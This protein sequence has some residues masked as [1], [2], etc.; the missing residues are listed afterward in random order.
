MRLKTDQRQSQI[1]DT[2]INIIHQH[3]YSHLSIRELANQVG[4]SQPALYRHFT[5]KDAI[6]LGILDRMMQLGSS[7]KQKLETVN[8]PKEKIKGFILGHTEFLQENPE[9]TSVVFSEDIFQD[10]EQAKNK[11]K[12]IL[13]YRCLILTEI[14]A[15]A[16]NNDVVVDVKPQDLSMLIIGFLRLAILNWRL[17]NF[18]DSLKDRVN[19]MI[20]TI[21]KLIFI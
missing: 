18:Q 6:I 9:M 17:N 16:K 7:I 11:L 15:E 5:N 2:A 20:E 19:Q 1:I 3:G 4:I 12:T 10:N 8:D 21:E 13:D 14:I